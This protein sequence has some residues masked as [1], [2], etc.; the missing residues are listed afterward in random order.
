MVTLVHQNPK[1]SENREY[2]DISTNNV[3]VSLWLA[4][5]PRQ[6]SK[7]LNCQDG[8]EWNSPVTARERVK[9]ETAPHKQMQITRR[10]GVLCAAKRVQIRRLLRST[11][12]PMRVTVAEE[13]G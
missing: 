6:F 12:H 2:Y 3:D 1:L 11:C 7:L 8:F 13:R 5:M 10:Y 4:K 9:S